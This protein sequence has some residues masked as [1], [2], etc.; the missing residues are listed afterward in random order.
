MGFFRE[1]LD[2]KVKGNK[3]SSKGVKVG[4]TG[5]KCREEVSFCSNRSILCSKKIV[6]ENNKIDNIKV[7][8]CNSRSVRN[9]I[10]LLRGLASVESP[11]V[12][13]ITET[14][15]DSAG[16]DF[17][18]EFEIDG[19]NV[20]HKDRLGRSGGGVAIYV[21]QSLNSFISRSVKSGENSETLWVEIVSGRERLLLGCVYRPPSLSRELTSLIFQEITAAAARFRNLCIMG[22][23]NYRNIDWSNNTGDNVS[24]EFLELINDNFLRQLI[25]EPTRENNILDLII[26]NRDDLVYNLEVGGRLGNSDHE[27]I[28]FNIQWVN[29][30]KN[31]NSALVP[32]FR[33][34][35]Y[36]ALRKHLEDEWKVRIREGSGQV[37]E[38]VVE[39]GSGGIR[40][41]Q[42][43][44][45]E[46][47]EVA[48]SESEVT[49][50]RGVEEDYKALVSI[51]TTGQG[52]H[53]PHRKMRSGNNDPK[54]M[55]GRLKGLIGTKRGIYKRLKDGEIGLRDRYNV[56]ARTVRKETRKAKR[57]Y[58]IRVASN[59]KNNP[60]GFFQLYKTKNRDRIGPIK[61]EEEIL[62]NNRE[63]SEALNKYFVSVFTQEDISYL[64][65]AV[66]VFRGGTDNN[67]SDIYINREEVIKEIDRLNSTKSPGVDLVY[68]R[69]LKECR[70]IVSV[71]LTDIFNKSVSTG[72]VPSLWRQANVVPI[73]KKGD[74]S[75]MS[76]Y[77]PISLTSVIGKMLESIIARKIREHLDFHKLITD[78]Q[79]GFTKGKSCVTNLLSFYRTVYEAAD[80]DDNYDVIYLDFSKAFD[81]VPHERLLRKI[82][83]HGI[84]GRVF[85]WIRSWLSNR[86]Q[87]V[88]I[89]GEKS[90]WGK[91]TSGVPQGSVLGPLLF[92]IYINDLDTGVSSNISKFADDT[93]LGRRIVSNDD[94][95]TLQR[96]LDM[97]QE[98]ATKWQMDFNTSKCS[99]L[100]I[101]K[102]NT[103]S[104]YALNGSV[105]RKINSER[106]L[107]VLVSQDLRPREQCI[108]A[109]NKANRILGFISR[110][111]TNRTPEVIL[112]LYLALVRPHLDYAV[113]FWSPYFRMDINRLEAIQRR[114]TKMISGIRNLDYKDRLERLQLHSLERRR[115][116]G[117]LIE[118]FKWVRGFNKGDISKVLIVS[119]PGITRTN[120]FKLDKFR[121][122]KEIG[123]NWFTNRVVDEWNRLSRDVVGA[124][125][126]DCFKKRLDNFMD[127]DGRW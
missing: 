85:N 75:V 83:S 103:E 126:L 111:V 42:V 7:Y 109:R 123:R 115:L 58:E 106:D 87:R 66:Q 52:I 5:V 96:E 1:G 11:E 120:G 6:K 57:N 70:D 81:R 116:R 73:F 65:D 46:V 51:V 67:L 113:Q 98:W 41:C 97:L 15:I 47:S 76:N 39:G 110:T 2:S 84:D 38:L 40:D 21:K 3:T 127:S 78:S 25:N 107:G 34:G 50:R 43:R 99:V 45:G 26:T 16:R 31:E 91:V 62:V 8:Y 108:S 89:N 32:D 36:E 104:R 69:V 125:T 19:Y 122:K 13:A 61:V 4:T 100:H 12:I 80:D 54:W 22:D 79:H 82:K 44:T 9:K 68:P 90:F 30:L 119:D 121:F 33:R 112:K 72:E 94:K 49:G 71:V 17:K 14:W 24:E 114:M 53:I 37:S 102:H 29:G 118:V 59:V 117:D 48:G 86:E 92:I 63:M 105:L 93:K 20:F 60:K 35:N 77:R 28:R 23:F 55:T 56:L 64:P 88:V 74:R 10:D 95:V 18:S 101:G 124:T 27:E